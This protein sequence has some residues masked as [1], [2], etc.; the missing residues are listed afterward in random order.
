MITAAFIPESHD[1][2]YRCFYPQNGGN[3]CPNAAVCCNST[4]SSETEYQKHLSLRHRPSQT[5]VKA[6]FSISNDDQP[7]PVTD[8]SSWYK[9]EERNNLLVVEAVKNNSISGKFLRR[10]SSQTP[11]R[12]SRFETVSYTSLASLLPGQLVHSEAINHFFSKLQEREDSRCVSSGG[13]LFLSTYVIDKMDGLYEEHKKDVYSHAVISWNTKAQIPNMLLRSRTFIPVH[14]PGGLGH[15]FLI[16]VSLTTRPRHV[17]FFN[18]LNGSVPSRY[19]ALLKLYIEGE[20]SMLAKK[21]KKTQIINFD[22]PNEWQFEDSPDLEKAGW[23]L[24]KQTNSVDCGVFFCVTAEL[25]SQQ[26]YEITDR[27]L[28]GQLLRYTSG[29]IPAFRHHVIISLLTEAEITPTGQ[30]PPR[31]SDVEVRLITAR[32]KNH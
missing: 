27:V 25:R 4:F 24:P 7:Q 10:L 9:F 16:E 11:K 13:C 3:V 28:L 23:Y 29:D 20:Y 6:E 30:P 19:K 31:L 5:A 1:D 17:R 32:S 8:L 14:I 26:Q 15:W 12:I 21:D 2:G 18:S 22:D